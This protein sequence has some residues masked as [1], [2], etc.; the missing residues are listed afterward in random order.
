MSFKH[1][2]L[3]AAL[4]AAA[5]APRASRPADAGPDMDLQYLALIDS[6]VNATIAQGEIPG[7]VV[8]IV[9]QGTLVYEKAFG[10]KAVVP[11]EEPMTVETMFD[12]ASLSKCVGTTIAVMQL[13]EKGKLRLVDQ[14]DYYFPDFKPW[15]D[16]ATGELVPITI[17]QL[18]THSSGL[19]PYLPDVPAFLDRYGDKC[20]ETLRQYICTQ[21]KRNFRPGTQQLYSC[22]NFI[23]LQY[24]VE[25]I[26]GERL[27]DYV[28]RN[29]F[30]VLGL[31]HTCYF[32]EQDAHKPELAP[33]CAPTQQQPDGSVLKA[34]VH[35]PIANLINGGN[36]GN[37]GVFSDVRDLA[38]ICTALMNGGQYNGRR[39]LSPLTVQRMFAVPAAD[40]PA[41]ARALG[42]DT[43][44]TGPYTSG[45]VF[46][47]EQ[48]RGHTGYTGTSLLLDPVTQTAVII[49]TNRVH[50]DDSGSTT[51]LRS[52]VAS[53][54][55][56]SIGR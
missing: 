16:P 7:A 51:R 11:Q 43:Y 29:V 23:T 34:Q 46:P 37:A 19:D 20:P 28:Q 45:D 8:G 52:V 14:V 33:L 30:D 38:V 12:L 2:L 42:W 4:L 18:L 49:L 55:A 22:L 41:V 26:T 10:R 25:Q 47:L 56:A 50:P 53:I 3:A 44:T 17:Q 27:C 21:T 54:T 1:Y 15:K 36:S 39:I 5:C 13:A 48:L 31:E 6:A 9:H 35:D 32:P 24:I 40:D